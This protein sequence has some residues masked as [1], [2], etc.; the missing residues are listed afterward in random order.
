MVRFYTVLLSFV[1]FVNIMYSQRSKT[2]KIQFNESYSGYSVYGYVEV[3][4]DIGHGVDNQ[5]GT[6][7]RKI[8]IESVIIDGRNYTGN[9]LYEYGGVSFPMDC[10]GYT[11]VSGKVSMYSSNLSVRVY[12][13]L[14]SGG[15]LNTGANTTQG[16]SFS[17]GVF[18]R[19]DWVRTGNVESIKIGSVK[20]NCDIGRAVNKYKLKKKEEAE[21]KQKQSKYKNLIAKGKNTSYSDNSRLGYLR[22]A[23]QYATSTYEQNQVNNAIRNLEQ[24][25]ENKN[26]TRS[27]SSNSSSTVSRSYSSSNN[28]YSNSRSYSSGSSSARSSSSSVGSSST[29]TKSTY[30]TDKAEQSLANGNLDEAIRYSKMSMDKGKDISRALEINRRA[31]KIRDEKKL[32][33]TKQVLSNTQTALQQAQDKDYIGMGLTTA[34]NLRLQNVGSELQGAAVAAGVVMQLFSDHQER[35]RER[36]AYE[37]EQRRIKEAEEKRERERIEAER[38]RKKAEAE[39]K[40][41][42][43]EQRLREIAARK[44]FMGMLKDHNMPYFV[45]EAKLYFF[46]V[47]EESDK[48]IE[49]HEFHLI[50]NSDKNLPYKRDVVSKFKESYRGRGFKNVYLYGP[51]KTKTEQQLKIKEI[52]KNAENS[53]VECL[54]RDYFPPSNKNVESNEGIAK[55][56]DARGNLI[57]EESSI[58]IDL[59]NEKSLIIKPISTNTEKRYDLRGNLIIENTKKSDKDSDSKRK[60]SSSKKSSSSS[61]EKRYDLRGNLIKD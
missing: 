9:Q 12:G 22:E 18:N 14:K 29:K 16:V 51:F 13:T 1:F 27:S 55:R 15:S 7:L 45:T 19:P 54:L 35:K 60:S 41:L 56:Y 21:K 44:F 10:R 53:Y 42:L 34:E 11:W 49:I 38:A 28:S 17:Q 36:E 20:L 57:K 40:R 2:F 33:T 48:E 8:I 5:M 61:T 59:E 30:Y 31:N 24:S 58:S 4:T 26:K 46:F 37:R 3:I 25:I 39:R 50:P 43:E 23:R 52:E 6:Q 32:E 47:G